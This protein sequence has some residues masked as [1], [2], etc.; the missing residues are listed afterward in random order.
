[1][2]TVGTGV[3]A[4]AV[5]FLLAVGA[6]VTGRATAGVTSS[7]SLH[8]SSTIEAWSICT[9]HS[10]HLTILSIE[11]LGACARV[12]VHQIVTA[13]AVLARIAVALIGLDLAVGATEARLAGAS[14]AP[15]AGVCASGI[16]LARL[17]IGAEVKV[18]V[19]EQATPAFLAVTMKRLVAGSMQTPGV[20][21]AL[22]ALGALPPEATLALTRGLTITVLVT[23][24]RQADGLIAVYAF[25]T[26]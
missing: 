3:T 1:M 11:A 17:M 6:H 10:A 8:T 13:A 16:I 25:P 21:L 4:A 9:G 5:N 18:L 24:A 23:A 2:A 14:V 26:R 19:A 7:H 22:I 15:L 20:P 12:V